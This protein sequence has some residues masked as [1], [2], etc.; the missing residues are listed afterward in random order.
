MKVDLTKVP[1]ELNEEKI[2]WVE[3]TLKSLTI[4][5]KIKQLFV[6]LTNTKEE[7]SL[8]ELT[9]QCQFGGV[10]YN[11][12][13]SKDLYNHNKVLQE[14]SKLP[15]LICANTENGGNG[16]CK[17]GTEIG[18]ET[19]VAATNNKTYAYSLG[20]VSAREARAC[21]V[22]VVFA[23]I[24][25]IHRNFHNPVISTR[26]FG[27]DPIRVRDMS[28]EYLKACQ[29]EGILACAKHFPG[30]GCD[31]RDQHLASSTNPCSCEEWDKTYG[32]V[33]QSLI[34]K[35]LPMIMAGHIKL[36]SYQKH[37]DKDFDDSKIRPATTCKELITDLLKGK[38]GFNGLV[39][40]DATHM[41]ALTSSMKRSEFLPAIINAG[42]DMIL[43]YNDFEEDM[44]YM[45]DAY[46]NDVLKEERI[47][48]AVRR[49]LGLKA[50]LG[51]DT[52]DRSSIMPDERGLQIVGCTL[53]KEYANEVAKK[54]IT[55]V[56]NLDADALP[57]DPKK[58]KRILL[59]VQKDENPFK[60][61]L[62]KG[63]PTIF[64][65]LKGKL[66]EE[67]F[68]VEIF[69]SLMDKIQSMPPKEAMSA[70]NNVYGNKTPVRDLTSN[71]D[72]IIQVADFMSHN[73]VQRISWK[74]SKGT[75]DVPWYVHELKTIF[76]SLNCPFH[77][78]DVP[79]VR[80]Y[81]NCY[82]KNKV[83]IDH[84]VNKLVGKEEF[85]GV[86]PVDAFCGCV[87]TKY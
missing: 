82:D 36:P 23:P 71:Y 57:L 51:L 26:T 44:K 31:E 27:N 8:I 62:P 49:I 79:Q 2:E 1:Y 30:D 33:Y 63:M 39:V 78:F 87:D 43:F 19:K 6:C 20:K 18:N 85:E 47:D 74:L 9:K 41:V 32:M 38:M 76:I 86:S 24:V 11:P 56:K 50:K 16:A 34:D 68:E 53:H 69:T 25:D 75:A 65:Y 12:L 64:D 72:V 10:R 4:D 61:F 70:V 58:D 5:E 55:L 42:C 83:T 80:T 59:V 29:E 54:A 3:S 15:V 60:M 37:F 81:I 21:G 22:N 35:K 45:R 52:K 66:E 84:L 73:T 46:D 40:T 14:N 77:L 17:D 13:S 67:G 28:L 48:D 7:E